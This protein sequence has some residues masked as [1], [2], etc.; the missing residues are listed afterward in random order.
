MKLSFV[1]VK[2]GEVKLVQFENIR[3][4]SV[5][6]PNCLHIFLSKEVFHCLN[7][8]F[9]WSIKPSL[10][11]EWALEGNAPKTEEQILFLKMSILISA[12]SIFR[13][14]QLFKSEAA[15]YKRQMVLLHYSICS[16]YYSIV[17]ILIFSCTILI[18]IDFGYIIICYLLDWVE[19]RTCQGHARG[20]H[21]AQFFHHLK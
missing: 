9:G 5:P 7:G 13:G 3:H 11:K 10:S 4:F 16:R 18:R 6:P 19:C 15:F 2:N 21:Y 8:V 12:M 14:L 17:N 20:H 1:R